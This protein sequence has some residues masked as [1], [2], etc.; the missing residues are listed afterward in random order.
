MILV[1]LKN[2]DLVTVMD[3]FENMEVDHLLIDTTTNP[4][5]YDAD[6]DF[7]LIKHFNEGKLNMRS[8]VK[9][10][11][12]ANDGCGTWPDFIDKIKK[13][14]GYEPKIIRHTV[15]DEMSILDPESAN[16]AYFTR[17][18]KTLGSATRLGNARLRVKNR[19]RQTKL[20]LHRVDQYLP[21]CVYRWFA[22]ERPFESRSRKFLGTSGELDLRK[23]AKLCP[24]LC[25]NTFLEIYDEVDLESEERDVIINLREVTVNEIMKALL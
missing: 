14:I 25:K 4:L 18:K 5:G 20:I 6:E 22:F 10:R 8:W 12:S 3:A 13:Q 24:T 11:F 9:G 15:V 1:C 23:F 2:P 7:P 16:R 21:E 17:D 19:Q